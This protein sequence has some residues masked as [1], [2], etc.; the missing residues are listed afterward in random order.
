VSVA[1]TAMNSKSDDDSHFDR[2]VQL[3]NRAKNAKRLEIIK[4]GQQ[5]AL[6]E[7]MSSSELNVKKV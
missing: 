5:K 6:K 3:R 1:V 7:L 4:E 2:S